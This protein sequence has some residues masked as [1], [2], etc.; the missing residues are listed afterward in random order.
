MNKNIKQYTANNIQ[1]GLSQHLDSH[2]STTVAI[3]YVFKEA[4]FQ[5]AA[6][7]NACRVLAAVAAL[8][9]MLRCVLPK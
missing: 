1:F 6:T 3:G 2:R 7:D 5:I 8:A 4:N 9:T